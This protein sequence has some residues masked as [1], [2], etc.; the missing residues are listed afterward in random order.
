MSEDR[1]SQEWN[2]KMIRP[3]NQSRIHPE[4]ECGYVISNEDNPGWLFFYFPVE[5]DKT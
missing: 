5:E 1:R 4:D 3:A 2:V